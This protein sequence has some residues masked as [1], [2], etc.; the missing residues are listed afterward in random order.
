MSL[1]PRIQESYTRHIKSHLC[2]L[3]VLAHLRDP[4][5]EYTVGFLFGD[6]MTFWIEN[7]RES[8]SRR[9]KSVWSTSDISSLSQDSML[10]HAYGWAAKTN[11]KFVIQHRGKYVTCV[12]KEALGVPRTTPAGDS[13]LPPQLTVWS[14]GDT[15]LFGHPEE[16]L[17]QLLPWT[18]FT[19]DTFL[20]KYLTRRTLRRVYFGLQF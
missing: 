20:T 12:E 3:C 10:Q 2:L 5:K 11:W 15:L 13:Y 14:N 7:C 1:S 9:D 6:S 16:K 8:C 17:L 18:H 4:R 19:V